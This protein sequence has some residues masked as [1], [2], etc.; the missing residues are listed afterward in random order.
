VP[1]EQAHV[2]VAQANQTTLEYLLCNVAAHSP[3]VAT[4]AFY[5]ALHVAEAVFAG[6]LEIGHCA[7]HETRNRTL[8]VKYQDMW[9]HYRCLWSLSRLARYLADG[10]KQITSFYSYMRPE[11]VKEVAVAHLK[12]VQRTAAEHLSAES[13]QALGLPPPERARKTHKQK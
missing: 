9:R 12:G 1:S 10:Q 6:N 5:K 2:E 3:W 4:V 11:S 8:K 13:L 7:D